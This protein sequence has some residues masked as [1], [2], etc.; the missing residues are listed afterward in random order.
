MIEV[1]K[2]RCPQDGHDRGWGLEF[3]N[4]RE[5]IEADPDFRRAITRAE[6]RTV[7]TR[8]RLRNL[9]LLI[10][11]YLPSLPPG[12]IIEFGSYRGGSAFFM[13]ELAAKYLPGTMVYALDTFA[14]MPSTDSGIDRHSPGDLQADFAEAAA[15]KDQFGLTNLR[16]IK[17]PFNETA[18]SILEEAGSLRLAHIDCDIYDSVLYAYDA[19]RRFMVPGGYL[20][21]D[22]ATAPSCLGATE[23][24][25]EAV[26]R[27]DGLLSEQIW[28]HH[29]FR[30]PGL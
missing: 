8:D 6:G 25:E 23:A 12:H 20:V 30:A 28:P 18:P 5:A 16:L 22:D 9:F 26:I 13:A 21:F 15:A 1:R 11:R 19:C 24:V 4:H 3:G 27:R 29:V 17:G 2:G 7:V 10:A 14:G